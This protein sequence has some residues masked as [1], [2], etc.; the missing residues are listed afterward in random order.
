[1]N[2]ASI[3][4]AHVA[5]FVL[6]VLLFVTLMAIPHS[7]STTQPT[8]RKR[9]IAFLIS[10]SVLMSFFL[11]IIMIDIAALIPPME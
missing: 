2:I 3:T 11:V 1:M 5:G 9:H 6:T 7:M 4:P 8:H 10:S